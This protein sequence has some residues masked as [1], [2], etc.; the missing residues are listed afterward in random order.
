MR[1]SQNWRWGHRKW[2]WGSDIQM[3]LGL[4]K[5]CSSARSRGA[6][7]RDS[8]LA[9][10]I[11]AP[12]E[13]GERT[14]RDREEKETTC[15]ERE[16]ENRKRESKVMIWIEERKWRDLNFLELKLL[17]SYVSNINSYPN[18]IGLKYQLGCW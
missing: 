15:K 7:V 10:C 11:A 8:R 5:W 17:F 14:P 12:D 9:M 6:A 16:R 1:W 13:A 3:V 2:G 18:F 4:K